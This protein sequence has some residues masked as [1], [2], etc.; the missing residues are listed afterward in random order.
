MKL[1]NVT[2]TYGDGKTE[3]RVRLYA[4][5]GKAVTQDGKTL[6]GSIDVL[7]ADGWYEVDYFEPMENP[8]DEEALT[9][10][11]NELT[12]ADDPD[13]ISAAETLITDR[14]KEDM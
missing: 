3:Q 13:L 8:T 6:Y 14:I 10:Y 12:G 11:A 4:D 1:V 7:S 2:Y 5:Q 9:R